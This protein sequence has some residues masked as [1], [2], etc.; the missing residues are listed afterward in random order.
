MVPYSVL[1]EGNLVLFPINGVH[2]PSPIMVQDR[3]VSS[4]DTGITY[5]AMVLTDGSLWTF[6]RNHYGQ[7]GDGT[8][9]DRLTPVKIVDENVTKV[10][11]GESHTVFLKNNGSVWGMGYN[12]DYRLGDLMIPISWFLN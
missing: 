2:I 10:A 12:K 11:S 6:G 4:Y 3:N 5:S 1:E 9:T 7:L 8:T